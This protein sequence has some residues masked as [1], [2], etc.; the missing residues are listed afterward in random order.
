MAMNI[1]SYIYGHYYCY[2]KKR[3]HDGRGMGSFQVFMAMVGHLLLLFEIVRDI[4][5][6]NGIEI[7]TKT[8]SGTINKP[9]LLACSI[10]VMALFWYFY[11]PTRTKK[12]LQEYTAKFSGG[13]RLNSVR[14]FLF[15]WAAF[16]LFFVLALIR[17]GGFAK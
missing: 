3:G 6:I 12:I 16:F 2:Y 17:Q 8:S 9:L 1:Y 10:P 4:L 11:N 7:A 14:G 5:H 15:A 13:K